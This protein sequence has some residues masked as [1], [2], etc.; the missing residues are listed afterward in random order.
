MAHHDA[1]VTCFV[2]E[3]TVQLEI[4]EEF[5]I[6]FRKHRIID[7]HLWTALHIESHR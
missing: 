5:D 4:C 2:L 6:L 7:G 3:Q 1:G